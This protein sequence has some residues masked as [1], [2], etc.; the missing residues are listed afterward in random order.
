MKPN[1]TLAPTNWLIITLAVLP[2]LAVA[3]MLVE[4]RV[5]T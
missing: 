5:D 4:Q 1:S 3:D 2:G